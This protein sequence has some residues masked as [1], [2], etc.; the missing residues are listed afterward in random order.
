MVGPLPGKVMGKRGEVACRPLFVCF[1]FLVCFSLVFCKNDIAA[2]IAESRSN[3]KMMGD[4]TKCFFLSP[5][6]QSLS[7]FTSVHLLPLTRRGPLRGHLSKKIVGEGEVS[8]L[9]K[10]YM[11]SVAQN[12]DSAIHLSIL[13]SLLPPLMSCLRIIF[14]T[15][16]GKAVG[17]GDDIPLGPVPTGSPPQ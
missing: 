4:V 3:K 5:P 17:D 7:R 16:P 15:P 13:S 1:C 12:V 14:L 9:L 8:G 2:R 11:V 6:P 10:L